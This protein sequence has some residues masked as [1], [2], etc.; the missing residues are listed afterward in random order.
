MTDVARARRLAGRIRQI[1]ASALEHGVKD[2]RLGMVTVTDTRVTADLREATVFYTVLGD[3]VARAETASALESAK[4]VLR[5]EVGRGTGV[6]F[7]PSLTFVL[8]E[9]PDTARHLEEL[10]AEARSADQ[11]VHALAVGAQ[12]AGE[13]QPYRS[14]PGPV[15]PAVGAEPPG[16]APGGGA[17]EETDR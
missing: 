14:E 6:R 9:V 13:P 8:D 10:I 3:D 12:P 5:A 4:G 11:R 16:D 2:P 7:T 1:V 17:G 15:A